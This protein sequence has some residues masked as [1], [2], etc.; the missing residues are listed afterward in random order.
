MTSK[1][2]KI[3]HRLWIGDKPPPIRMM[4]TW[5]NMNPDYE[6][7]R[8][9]E[10]EF[11]ARNMKFQCKNR[12]DEMEEING[13]ADI[14]RW[15]ILYKYGVYLLMLIHIVLNPLTNNYKIP[16]LSLVGNMK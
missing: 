9:S 2:P 8:W 3:I 12:I 1:I 7:I 5:K 13:K 6:Y 16:N 14:M 11:I 4:E 15:E 10:T